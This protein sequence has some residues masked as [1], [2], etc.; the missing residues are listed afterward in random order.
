MRG[1][2]TEIL[3]SGFPRNEASM[4]A[5][6]RGK[7]PLNKISV[8]EPSLYMCVKQQQCFADFQILL[9]DLKLLLTYDRGLCYIPVSD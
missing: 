4:G 5:E 1:S 3:L 8:P 7:K 9:R 6:F 2:G